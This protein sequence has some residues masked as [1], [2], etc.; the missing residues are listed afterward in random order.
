MDCCP[1]RWKGGS[2][3]DTQRH[4]NSSV[5][6]SNDG[7]YLDKAIKKTTQLYLLAKNEDVE[8][9]RQ[10]IAADRVFQIQGEKEY[11][12]EFF[13]ILDGQI[14]YPREDRVL[15]AGD[16]ISVQS[17]TGEAY[18]KTLTDVSVL[19][20]TTAPVFEDQREEIQRLV[21][22][23]DEVAERDQQTDEHCRRLQDLSRKTAEALGLDDRE[24][25]SLGYASFLHDIGKSKVPVAIL[26]K[27]GKPSDEE[28][29]IL[30]QH[31][32][33]GRDLILEHLRSPMFRRVAEI[34]HQHHERYDGGGYP[35]GLR[36]EEI[37][38]EAQILAV[39]DAY[40]A[41]TCDRPYRAGMAREDAL[42][43]LRACSGTQFSPR[44]VEAFL[45]IE[46]QV[47]CTSVK[48]IGVR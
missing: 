10:N 34:V 7:R 27:P 5:I 19:Y 45:R 22:L 14:H 30:K 28:W 1:C 6:I 39:V 36:G 2:K 42:E 4:S 44:V 46:Q 38:T 48:D 11:G 35:Q 43:E 13:Y 26:Q 20:I 24:I 3:L 12:M 29:A 33:W 41:M 18:F 47:H 8:I 23:N 25:F 17:V 32:K 21:S 16:S 40:D 15:S 37:L 9:I 31:S